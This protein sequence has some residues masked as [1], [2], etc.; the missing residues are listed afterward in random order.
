[1]SKPP[2]KR[3]INEPN[4]THFL[5]FTVYRRK[6]LLVSDWSRGLVCT[7]IDEAR[8]ELDYDLWAYVVMPEHVHVLVHPRP[9]TY[10]IGVFN[11]T[12]KRRVS[13]Q[14]RDR[15]RELGRDDW[16]D[17]LTVTV[18]G[19]KKFRFWQTGGGYDENL[20]RQKPILAVIDYIH[21]NPV[22]RGLVDRI[23]DWRWSSAAWYVSRREGNVPTSDVPIVPDPIWW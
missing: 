23:E 8:T 14:V 17:S 13:T 21:E 4:H 12:V 19:R 2:R 18:G 7:A 11:A 6:Q 5:T 3:T 1:M 15:L 10:D 20:W 9:K 22:R 16:I